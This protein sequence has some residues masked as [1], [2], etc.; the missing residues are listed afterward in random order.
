MLFPACHPRRFVSRLHR[1]QRGA[2]SLLT[3]FAVFMFTL[4]LGQIINTAR[5]IDDKLRMQNAADA[6]A[7]SGGVGIARGMNAIAFSN[8]LLCEVFGL[9]AYMRE[10]RDRHAD[11]FIPQVLAAWK[12]V[13]ECFAHQTQTQKFRGLGQAILQKIPVEQEMVNDF[14]EM[15][16]HQSRITLPLFEYVLIGPDGDP[17]RPMPPAPDGGFIPKFQRAVVRNTPYLSLAAAD[18]VTRR[19]GQATE[20]LHRNQ[21]LRGV[22]WR[23]NVEVAGFGSELDPQTRTIPAV[24]PSP[25]GPDFGAPNSN[26]YLCIS[27]S[28][29]SRLAHHYLNDWINHWQGPYFE[30][31]GSGPRGHVTAK[32]S[33][34]V[35]FFRIFACGQL[36]RLLNDEYPETNLPHVLRE[37]L[38]AHVS[39]VCEDECAPDTAD[40]N[41]ILERDYQFVA[42]AHWPQM[43]TMF[44]G[45]FQNPLHRDQRTYAVTFA[46]VEVYVPRARYACCPWTT[47]HVCY[48]DENGVR[49]PYTCYEDHYD[50]WPRQWDLFN[51]N[52]TARLVPATATNIP[53]IL[54][55]HPQ[56]FISGMLSGYQAPTLGTAAQGVSWLTTH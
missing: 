4:L 12:T 43:Q 48:R 52:W 29:R 42:T 3:V 34:Y 55:T 47:P 40:S 46:Q 27:R 11:Q 21:P 38:P 56:Q 39:D 14:S 24:D 1:D 31:D 32:M 15:A 30:W 50:N 41:A 8:H 18:D 45:L 16:W 10:A 23:T 17:Q 13:G 7:Y 37:I 35:N 54:Q 36:E 49:I 25:S 5:Q 53:V 44:P 9:T 26:C 20:R 6:A 33:N 19:F 22:F 2:I 28:Q 51:Q